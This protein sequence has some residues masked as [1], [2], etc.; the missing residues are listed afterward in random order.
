MQKKKPRNSKLTLAQVKE[1]R[2][3]YASGHL[4]QSKK[5]RELGVCERTIYRICHNKTW[6]KK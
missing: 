1:I 5:A 2:K 6:I 4:N 3:A